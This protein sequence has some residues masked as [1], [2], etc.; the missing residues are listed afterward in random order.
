MPKHGPVSTLVLLRHGES[1]WNGQHARFTGWADVPLTVRGRVE[2]V[3]AGQLLRARGFHASRVDVAFA[4]CL[5]V[6]R[7][8]LAAAC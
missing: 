2:A 8:Q 1:I 6:C 7:C 4:S 5:Q 3:Q